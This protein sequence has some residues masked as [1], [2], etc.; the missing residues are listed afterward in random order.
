MKKVCI[1]GAMNI[2]HMS[3]ISLYTK[4]FDDNGISY[5]L[6]FMDRYGIDEKSTATNKYTL[7]VNMNREWSKFKKLLVYIKFRKYA[8]SIIFKNKYDIVITWQTFTAYLL[9]DILMT[10]YKDRYIVN[11]RDYIIENIPIV[12]YLLKKWLKSQL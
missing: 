11:V 12:K 1:V 10:K 2:K 7:H 6:I 3:L 4:Y 5:D 9:A 8:K